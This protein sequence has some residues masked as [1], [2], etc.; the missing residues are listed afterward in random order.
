MHPA[1]ATAPG[2]S[3]LIEIPKRS[4]AGRP[5]LQVIREQIAVGISW[6]RERNSVEKEWRH[7]RRLLFRPCMY[8]G[9]M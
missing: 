3:R 6:E 9:Q 5:A 1:N 2:N 4:T 7:S 8:Q